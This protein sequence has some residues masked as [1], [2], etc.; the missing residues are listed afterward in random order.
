MFIRATSAMLVLATNALVQANP[1]SICGAGLVQCGPHCFNPAQNLYKCENDVLL[2]IPQGSAPVPAPAPAPAPPAPAPA[3]GKPAPGKDLNPPPATPGGRTMQVV[4][5]CPHD[6]WVGMQGN[7]LPRDGGFFLPKGGSENVQLP[8][9]WTAGRIW[10]RTGCTTQ[11]V[12]GAQRLVCATGDCGSE[13]NGF[14]IACK[15]IG[16]QAP[17]TLAEFTLQDGGLTDFYD[18]SNVDGYN[19]GVSIESFGTKVNNP[20]LQKFNCGNPTCTFDMS[21]CPPELKMVDASGIESCAAIHAAVHKPEQVAKFPILQAIAKSPTAVAQVSCSCDCGPDCGCTN[22]A[23]K[24]C[25]SPFNNDPKEVGGKCFVEQWPVSTS[26]GAGSVF[27]ARYDEVFK[28][29]CPDAYSW[30]F[31][32]HQSTYQCLTANYRVTFC[33]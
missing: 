29:Q 24:F 33:P 30:Q 11:N 3:P 1:V 18:L 15:G 19:V 16:G 7:P 12:G 6:V 8:Q 21:K 9:R 10:A 17:A 25:C 14:G 13:S 4:N 20:D 23:S 32:D 5:R 26:P 31:D 22:P 2:Q 28:S 27:P